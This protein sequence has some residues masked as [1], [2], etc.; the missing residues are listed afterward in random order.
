MASTGPFDS[1]VCTLG[2]LPP[3]SQG[4]G[5]SQVVEDKTALCDDS[6]GVKSGST[7]PLVE[8]PLRRCL[9]LALAILQQHVNVASALS[10]WRFWFV[11]VLWW[12][13]IEPSLALGF[14]GVP[15]VCTCPSVAVPQVAA[16]ACACPLAAA[17]RLYV[18]AR[19]YL[20]PRVLALRTWRR[21]L[22]QPRQRVRS[23]RFPLPVL[24]QCPRPVAPPL[25]RAR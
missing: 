16:R 15:L 5:A 20:E 19:H 10:R 21:W 25:V 17:F 7:S 8:A 24:V 11:P 13:R 22:S 18:H 1:T 6:R 3:G 23:R 14:R 12:L 2:G 4:L 9:V